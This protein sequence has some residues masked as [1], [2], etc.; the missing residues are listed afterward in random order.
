MAASERT[1][2]LCLGHLTMAASEHPALFPS[3]THCHGHFRTSSHVVP[4][5]HIA[6]AASECPTMFF[7]DTPPWLPQ[8]APCCSSAT[9]HHVPLQL[10][11]AMAA[12]VSLHVPL[13]RRPAMALPWC[14]STSP[15]S[16]TQLQSPQ[17]QSALFVY[18]G[19]HS[20]C[21]LTAFSNL[22][23][24]SLPLKDHRESLA[25]TWVVSG[26]TVGVGFVKNTAKEAFSAL[27]SP[28]PF[29]LLPFLCLQPKT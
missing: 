12:S 4:Q 21:F 17:K 20:I 23:R 13:Q 6:M 27:P 29:H 25:G 18:Q 3:E 28:C 9:H 1:T 14:P 11:P 7:C 5:R 19:K 2:M 22:S 10:H 8:S 16:N 26:G 24:W 15:P